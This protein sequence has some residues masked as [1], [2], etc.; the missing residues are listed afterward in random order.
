NHPR[1]VD[2][3]AGR[4]WTANA[5]PIDDPAAEALLGGDEAPFGSEYDL[6]ARQKQIRD[7]LA[8]IA[9]A[10]PLDMLKVQTDDSAIFLTRWRD[11]LTQLLDAAIVR[12]HPRRAEL[13][14]LVTEWNAR[15]T[16]DSVGYRLVRTFRDQT[17]SSVWRMMLVGLDVD[18]PDAPPPPQFE[19]A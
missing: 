3:P 5:R 17:E 8:A 10:T 9:Q 7:D 19:G 12:D 6:S 18:A 15:A 4:V 13:K 16:P 11:L 2:P 14:K 1:L